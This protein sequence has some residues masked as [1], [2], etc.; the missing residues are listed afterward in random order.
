MKN[1]YI[2][3]LNIID[4]LE[5]INPGKELDQIEILLLEH[6]FRYEGRKEGL[7]VGDLLGLKK[8]GSQATLHGRIKNL[9]ALGYIKLVGDKEDGRRKFVVPTKT[10]MK[11][12]QFMS[13]C[14]EN[15]MKI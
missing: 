8:L 3:F 4:T 14:L 15:S 2:R 12:I 6:I 11:Y 7:L 9:T 10:G 1:A 13:E 5:R